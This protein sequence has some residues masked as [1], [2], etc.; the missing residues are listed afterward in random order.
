MRPQTPML[1][2]E[3]MVEEHELRKE[4]IQEDYND[5]YWDRRYTVLPR[6]IPSFLQKMAGKVLSTGE[7]GRL[8]GRACILRESLRACGGQALA[9][10]SAR[11]LRL[12]SF[13]PLTLGGCLT[14]APPSSSPFSF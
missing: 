5:Q 7:R 14:A 2:S 9:G 6:Q 11:T 12:A 3:F 13:C 1:S 10:P 4:K 8:D